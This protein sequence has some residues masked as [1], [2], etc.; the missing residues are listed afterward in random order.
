MSEIFKIFDKKF[1]HTLI[2]T[3][4]H[5]DRLL[6]D[7]FFED[8]DIRK[9]DHN[10][11]IS[12]KKSLHYHQLSKLNVK[13]LDLIKKKKLK[14]DLIVFLGD[15][16]SVGLSFVLKKEGYSIAHIEAGMRSY[17][18]RMLEEINR[19]VCDRCSDFLF[20]YHKDYKK[21]LLKENIKK[22]VYV[23]GNTIIEPCKKILSTILKKR[24][25]NEKYILVDIH[26]PENFLYK[27]RLKKIIEYCY[28]VKE[29]YKCK[30]VFLK[31]KRTMSQLKTFNISTDKLNFISLQGYKNYLSLQRDAFFI[32]SDSGTAQEEPSIFKK[33][34]IVPRDF[35]ERPQSYKFNCS[36]KINVNN[37]NK[38][39]NKSVLWINDLINKK[40][41]SDNKWMGDGKTSSKIAKILELKL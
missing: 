19:V 23:V 7:I 22:N 29:T 9:P 30:I 3:G 28:F 39:W 5:F 18:D 2:H 37:K 20:V 25:I 11:K 14:P 15:S 4:Q 16:N 12:T 1:N 27:Q 6:S 24:L 38:S 41:K 40:I 8:L 32:F 36:F 31:F 21:N 34:V 26:R 17:D 13:F 35:T 33:P 10:L